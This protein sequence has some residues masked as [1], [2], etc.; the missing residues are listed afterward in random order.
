A[1][2]RIG[3]LSLRKGGLGHALSPHQPRGGIVSF[4]AARLIINSVLLLALLSELLLDRPRP[5]PH[6]RILDRDGV[7]ERA[8]P[9]PRPAFEQMQVLARALIISLRTE[10]RHVDHQRI[11]LPMAARVAVP[12]AEAGRQ[13]RTSVHDDVPLPP[14]PLTHIDDHG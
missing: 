8:R 10:V 12:L 13:V 6:R 3:T 9:G 5:R 7:F 1:Y 14:F 11:A 4:D 2:C